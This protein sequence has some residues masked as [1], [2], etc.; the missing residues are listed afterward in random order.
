[1][2]K[3]IPVKAPWFHFGVDIMGPLCPFLRRVIVTSVL[4]LRDYFSKFFEAVPD[5]QRDITEERNKQ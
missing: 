3:K 5:N 1:M 4:T 2:I